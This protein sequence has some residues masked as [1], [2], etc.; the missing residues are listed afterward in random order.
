MS[1]DSITLRRNGARHDMTV[2]G[3]VWNLAGLDKDQLSQARERIVNFWCFKTGHK[4]L[5]PNAEGLA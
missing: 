4:P 5:Y 1:K 2:A 3:T